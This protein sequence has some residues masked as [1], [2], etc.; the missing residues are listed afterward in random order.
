M[1]EAQEAPVQEMSGADGASLGATNIE[2][3]GVGRQPSDDTRGSLWDLEIRG[4]GYCVPR[5]P[6]DATLA[7][8]PSGATGPG[9]PDCSCWAPLVF[10]PDLSTGGG[11]RTMR[12]SRVCRSL[13]WRDCCMRRW[14]RPAGTSCVRFSLD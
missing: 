3:D 7:P 9:Y 12:S 4:V 14:P 10:H 2:V 1:S 6:G 5:S 13:P 11:W 8:G